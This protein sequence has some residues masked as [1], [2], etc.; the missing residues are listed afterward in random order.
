MV[1]V[2]LVYPC[3][4]KRLSGEKLGIYD[5]RELGLLYLATVLVNNSY[6]VEL[7]PAVYKLKELESKIKKI[8]SENNLKLVATTGLTHEYPAAQWVLKKVK[9]IDK[10]VTTVIGGQHV[11]WLAEDVLNESSYIDVVAIGEGESIILDLLKKEFKDVN[12]IAYRENGS[13][14]INKGKEYCKEIILLDE[15]VLKDYL[16]K[17]SEK[18]KGIKFNLSS[19]RGCPYNCLY[20]SEVKFWGNFVRNKPVEDTIKE[21]DIFCGNKTYNKIICFWDSTFTV[22]PQYT[23]E[24]CS[25]VKKKDYDFGFW[26]YTRVDTYNKEMAS[27]LRSAGFNSLA[28]GVE[29]FHPKV[30]EVMGK[31]ISE[32]QIKKALENAKELNQLTRVYFI[33][34]HPG[35]NPERALYSYQKAKQFMSLGLIDMVQPFIF[36]PYPATDVFKNPSRY[37]AEILSYNWIKY[38]RDT[39]PVIEY[40]D[41]SADE[42]Y[43]LFMLFEKLKMMNKEEFY[44][45][46]A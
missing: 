25:A 4:Y 37:N 26:C 40:K 39:Y 43:Y 11:T 12:G 45:V 15:N 33:T 14:K 8:V 3:D 35:D 17:I 44:G 36:V 42:I 27:V 7:L 24:L 5:T 29:H 20:C 9:E 21:L 23:K 6:S 16:R 46:D 30:L 1:D 2:L 10:N 22:N 34:G 19:S 38:M 32:E 18:F 28:F 13:I 41:F 31:N